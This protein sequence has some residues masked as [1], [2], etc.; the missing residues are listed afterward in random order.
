MMGSESS[1]PT[2]NLQEPP[3]PPQGEFGGFLIPFDVAV[4]P[5]LLK[6]ALTHRSWAF[7][8]GGAPHNERLEF[9][10][11]AVLGQ[12]VTARLYRDYPDLT[13]GELAKRRAALVS[14][15]ALA[16]IARRIELGASIRLGRGER[17]TGGRE[18]DSILADTLEAVIGAV[19]LSAGAAAA[20]QFV[21][22]L[23]APLFEDPERFTIL[24]DPKTTLQEEA[25]A[26]GLPHPSYEVT[27]EG[28]NHDRTYS[29]RVQL[30]NITGRGE[31][32]SKK[33]AELAAAR[34]VVT[35]LGE[36]GLLKSSRARKN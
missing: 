23:T 33:M 27:A 19:F 6:L 11:D 1:F 36:R 28:P 13:E 29:A 26:R 4:D 15:D 3:G 17:K 25:A 14:S 7:E 9:L 20:D 30:E 35:M 31:G 21:Q 5:E 16:E 8:H 2:S 10:G 34:E 24:V 32:S 18:K 22:D 12:S